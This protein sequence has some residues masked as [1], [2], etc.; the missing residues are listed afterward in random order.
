MLLTRGPAYV[1]DVNPSEV[2]A[3]SFLG[4]VSDGRAALSAGDP[5]TAEAKLSTGLLLWRGQA[6]V[7]VQEANFAPSAAARLEGERL[8]A[9][10]TL[11]DARLQLGRHR[12]LVSELQAA[13][14]AD[15]F[16]EHLHAQLMTALYRSGRQ[17]DSLAAFKRAR[18][19]LVNQL[20]VEPGRELRDL[21]RAVLTQAPELE[22]SPDWPHDRPVSPPVRAGRPPRVIDE[23]PLSEPTTLLGPGT[24]AP[25]R[26]WAF[27]LAG[28]GAVVLLIA[29]AA[30]TKLANPAGAHPVALGVSELSA[31]SGHFVGTL[32]L[33]S[34][35]GGA[36]SG[37]ASVWVTSPTSGTLYRIDPASA[38]VEATVA[39]GA[40]AGAVA[41]S[42]PVT[43]GW[44]T[45]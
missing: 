35:P 29:A 33:T 9:V 24:G 21:E 41:V 13:A 45:R 27:K 5:A 23:H 3:L 18:D 6:L 40:G 14:A 39:I 37:D 43:Y 8:L 12:E 38:A 1:L 28:T 44:P 36:A 31:A 15:P 32:S 25:G 34:E 30:L 20:G 2:D 26:G 7:D 11:F 4:L 22:L 42:G 10:E 17:A 19:L 16:R